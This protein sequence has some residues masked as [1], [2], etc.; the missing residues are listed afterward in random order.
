LPTGYFVGECNPVVRIRPQ[1][2][3]V[4]AT[5]AIDDVAP[6]QTAEVDCYP[7]GHVP[8]YSKVSVEIEQN[9]PANDEHLLELRPV[10][11]DDQE[12][13]EADV[14]GEAASQIAV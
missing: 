5:S 4:R 10:R 9:I 12:R 8:R 6:G 1:V 13:V 7:R 3:S 14:A 11:G 2:R